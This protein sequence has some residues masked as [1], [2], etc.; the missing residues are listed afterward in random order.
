[1][2]PLVRGRRIKLKYAHQ[3]GQNP[4]V[5]V[6]HGNQTEEVP[7]AYKRYLINVFRDTLDIQGTPIKLEFRSSENPFKGKRNILSAR[8]VRKRR[9]LIRHKKKT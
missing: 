2:P 6:I 7:G 9:R 4:P 1:Q 8:Q 3:G 5:I